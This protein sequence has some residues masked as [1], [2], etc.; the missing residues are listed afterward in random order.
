MKM[1][2]LDPPLAMQTIQMDIS[3]SSLFK[4]KLH[5]RGIIIF[6]HGSLSIVLGCV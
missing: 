5:Y 6:L 4:I 1:K 2:I 3:S